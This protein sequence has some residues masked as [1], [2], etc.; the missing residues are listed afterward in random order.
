MELD[1]GRDSGAHLFPRGYAVHNATP[2]SGLG[3]D[4]Y[5]KTTTTTGVAHG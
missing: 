4:A 3:Q 2:V 1:L 5:V